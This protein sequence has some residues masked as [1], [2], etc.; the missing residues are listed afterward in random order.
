MKRIQLHPLPLRIWHWANALMVILLLI[1]GIELRIPGVAA[2]QVNS[3]ALLAHRYTGWSMASSCL[4]WFV[5]SLI[6]G[7]LSRHYVMRR[8]DFKGI[9]RQLRFY[10][11]SIFRGEEN[12]FRA[13]PDERF[14]PLQKLAYRAIMCV[15]TP[16]IV[17]TGFFFS[18][19]PFFRKYILL[20][21][22]VKVLD[23]T[24]VIVAYMFALYLIVHIYM[25]T[26]G[27]NPFS[28]IRAMVVGYEQEPDEP[29]RRVSHEERPCE[30]D[31]TTTMIS[32]GE[33]A[34]F[35]ECYVEKEGANVDG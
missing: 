13:S 35:E 22:A 12:P 18:D 6:T 15:F 5:Y 23:A 24:H 28:H 17:V 8:G 25:A 9:F 34:T 4:F 19:I 2:L 11:F 32:P 14:N 31:A 10:L 29:D 33:A 26:L 27:R 20:L 16:I 3:P 7:N 1:T 30:P 21:N